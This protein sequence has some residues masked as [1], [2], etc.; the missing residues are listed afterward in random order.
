MP[1]IVM[2]KANGIRFTFQ[3]QSSSMREPDEIAATIQPGTKAFNK[4]N[5]KAGTAWMDP[6]PAVKKESRL[7]VK[8]SRKDNDDV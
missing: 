5:D 4:L 1:H 6:K 2:S 7:R 8:R 3:V